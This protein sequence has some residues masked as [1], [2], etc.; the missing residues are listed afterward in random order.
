MAGSEKTDAKS[1]GNLNFTDRV[2]Y[3]LDHT[4]DPAEGNWITMGF[5]NEKKGLNFQSQ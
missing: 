5:Q 3:F 4:N 1:I 2:V